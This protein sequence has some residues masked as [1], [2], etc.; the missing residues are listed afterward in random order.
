MRVAV[1][2]RKGMGAFELRGRMVA[3]H[4][5]WDVIELDDRKKKITKKYDVIVL[6]K[7]DLSRIAEVRS[8][9]RF[10]VWDAL[11]AF[12]Q[13]YPHGEAEEFWEFYQCKIGCDAIIATSP[14]C[15]ETMRDSIGV[16]V[17]LL[18]HHFDPRIKPIER[19]PKGVV[20]Y[21]GGRQ[22]IESAVEAIGFACQEVGREFIIDESKG[23]WQS[24]VPV[25]LAMHPRLPLFNSPVMRKCKPQIKMA[26][27][28]AARLPVLATDDPAVTS[29]HSGTRTLTPREFMS[30][31][32]LESAIAQA[33]NDAPP[34]PAVS[35]AEHC[36]NLQR[37]IDKI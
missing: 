4:L 32:C 16:P 7:Y 13:W 36:Q 29:L 30:V 34:S 31:E 11:D 14:A 9:C 17:W 20:M 26:N 22:Y 28:A 35:L 6:V 23:P 5:G 1:A 18:P 8:A 27:A 2:G 37:Q 10:L 3:K 15:A 21:W 12:T 19:D 33:V 25:S 24:R